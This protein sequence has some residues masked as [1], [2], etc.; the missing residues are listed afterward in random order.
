MLG[1]GKVVFIAPIGTA[2]FRFVSNTTR[3]LDN[4]PFEL[5][6][7]KIR[8]ES[9]FNIEVGQVKSYQKGRVFLAGDAAHAHSPA[10]GRGMNL[11]MADAADLA[12]KL[13]SGQF[14]GY[15]KSRYQEGKKI[16]AGSEVLRKVLTAKHPVK[17]YLALGLLKCVANIPYLQKKFA[18]R[19]LYG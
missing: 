14:E 5:N 15:T 19:F 7:K 1:D 11:G 18:S 10:G 9:A 13:V 8:R 16:I 2:R 17:R 12:E 6:I 3:V 4:L